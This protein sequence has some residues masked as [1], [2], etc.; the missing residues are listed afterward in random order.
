MA[1]GDPKYVKGYGIDRAK[2]AA[3]MT[4]MGGEATD[5][6]VLFVVQ[7]ILQMMVNEYCVVGGQD[8]QNGLAY[9]VISLAIGDES[10]GDSIEEL[11]K[12]DIPIPNYL[13]SLESALHGPTVFEFVGW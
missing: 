6:R 9:N 2:I 8:L 11:E 13:R 7:G 12:K 4:Q 5:G 1:K 10:F 3:Q